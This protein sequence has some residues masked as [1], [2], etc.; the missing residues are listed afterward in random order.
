LQ[1]IDACSEGSC[2]RTVFRWSKA[3]EE[4]FYGNA[5]GMSILIE[6]GFKESQYWEF[7]TLNIDNEG[8]TAVKTKNTLDAVRIAAMFETAKG[9][10]VLFAGSGLLMLIHKDIHSVAEQFV[11]LLHLNPAKH[12]PRIFLDA[13][14]HLTDLQLWA[15]A[16]SALSYAVVR[17]AEAYGLWFHRQWAEWFGFLTGGMYIPLELYEMLHGVTWIKLTI[18]LIN[19]VVV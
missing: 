18:L 4:L 13:V 19:L 15:L 3:D 17:F 12:Y 11:R 9:L 5:T 2:Y 1:S 16:F 8:I 14:T 6:Y 7:P 10:L